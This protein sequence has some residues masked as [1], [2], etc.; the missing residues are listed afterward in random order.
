[1]ADGGSMLYWGKGLPYGGLANGTT[2]PGSMLYWVGGLPIQ[3]LT[4]PN[5]AIYNEGVTESA[6][7]ADTVTAAVT[8]PVT[9][10]ESATAKDTVA[11]QAEL[12]AV[13]AETAAR[14][15]DDLIDEAPDAAARLALVVPLSIGAIFLILFST[16]GSVRQALLTKSTPLLC[17]QCHSVAGHP[18]APAALFLHGG[19]GAG[20]SPHHRRL[21]DPK[22]YRVLLFD[23][24]GCGQSTP[25]ASLEANTTWHLVADIERLRELMGSASQFLSS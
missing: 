17:Q 22:K 2:D 21:F 3:W 9:V 23:Q 8:I 5:N 14:H 13:V 18:G 24:R 15:L 1:M 4:T 16:F 7:A 10:A 25:H 6:S 19:P 11:S 12:V 20:C